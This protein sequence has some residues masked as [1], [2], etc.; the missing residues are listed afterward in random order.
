MYV[1]CGP[2]SLLLLYWS[3]CQVLLVCLIKQIKTSPLLLFLQVKKVFT[4][5]IILLFML[6]CSNS[7]GTDF[8]S[9]E[10]S[11]LVTLHD[12]YSTGKSTLL[13][14]QQPMDHS[15][16]N[17]HGTFTLASELYYLTCLQQSLTHWVEWI[18]S[19]VST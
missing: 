12:S 16:L 8:V 1:P 17:N 14:Q 2:L 6:V 10:L 9:L 13:F 5:I 18:T 4:I 7:P 15:L 11:E 3:D 19:N